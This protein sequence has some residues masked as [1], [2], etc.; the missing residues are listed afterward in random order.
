[1]TMRVLLPQMDLLIGD[2]EQSIV[3]GTLF[4]FIVLALL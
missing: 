3:W 2:K 1:M 4:I